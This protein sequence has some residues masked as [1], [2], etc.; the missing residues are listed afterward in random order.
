[1]KPEQP[2]SIFAMIRAKAAGTWGKVESREWRAVSDRH[3]RYGLPDSGYDS[4]PGLVNRATP[5]TT[6]SANG[7]YLDGT[8]LKGYL[9]ALQA[10]CNL[11]RLGATLVQL[12]KGSTTIP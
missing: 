8:A 3:E 5:L 6:A 4:I 1:M 9:P 7:G 12:E 10:Q 2:F 11:V